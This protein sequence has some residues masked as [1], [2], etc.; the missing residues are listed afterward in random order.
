MNF[1][2]IYIE[3]CVVNQRSNGAHYSLLCKILYRT[4]GWCRA[5]SS[6]VVITCIAIPPGVQ[7]TQSR[8]RIMRQQRNDLPI[9]FRL[10]DRLIHFIVGVQLN[11]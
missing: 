5:L 7:G 11:H 3:C 9:V 6:I 10:R 1:I 8:P 4:T 2:G